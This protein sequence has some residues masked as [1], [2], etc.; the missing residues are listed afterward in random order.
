[1]M[2][3]SPLQSQPPVEPSPRPQGKTA[4]H[5]ARAG[6]EN[7]MEGKR[8]AGEVGGRRVLWSFAVAMLILVSVGAASWLGARRMARMNS[9][10]ERSYQ[11]LAEVDTL[12][13]LMLGA[14]TD[15]RGFMLTGQDEFL[16]S[17]QAAAG[18]WRGSFERLRAGVPLDAQ[19]EGASGRAARLSRIQKLIE[20]KLWMLQKGI[21]TRRDGGVVGAA[22]LL[23]NGRGKLVMDQIRGEVAGLK[24]DEAE[25]IRQASLEAG[26]SAR[27]LLWITGGGS[28]WALLLAGSALGRLGR[29][30]RGREAAQNELKA[31]FAAMNEIVLVLGRDGKYLRVAA[32]PPDLPLEPEM[33]LGRTLHEVWPGLKQEADKALALIA[34]V[35]DEDLP[36]EFEYWLPSEGKQ[37][38]FAASVVPLTPESVLWV[39]RDISAQ[40][41][42]AQRRDLSRAGLRSV[43]DAA[44]ELLRTPDVDA[45]LRRAVEL[46]REKFGLERAAIFLV[47]P[48]EKSVR[49]TYGTDIEGS[50]TDERV[51]KLPIPPGQTWRE[52]YAPVP[53][54]QRWCVL[55]ERLLSTWDGQ[56]NQ[57]TS[58]RSEAAV[59]LI[60][61]ATGLIGSFHNDNG[62]S[63]SSIDH[64]KQELIAV[65][66]SILGSLI[67]SK[68]GEDALRE[69]RDELEG[70]VRSRTAELVPANDDLQAQIAERKRAQAQEKALS[71]GL[72]SILS[73][74][75]DLLHIENL[76]ALLRR[77]IELGR[78]R[79]G[80]ERCALFLLTPDGKYLQGAYGINMDGSIV[81]QNRNLVPL[82]AE[83]FSNVVAQAGTRWF[84]MEAHAPHFDW[85]EEKGAIVETGTRGWQVL[86]PIRASDGAIGVLFNDAAISGAALDEVTQNTVTLF[87]SLLGGIIER[88]KAEAALRE[89][90]ALLRRLFES[91]PQMIWTARTDG[92]LEYFNAQWYLYSGQSREQSDG[93]GWQPILHPEDLEP[94]LQQWKRSLSTGQEL[95]IE[96][97]LKR[98][99][100]L[101]RWHLCRAL[102]VRSQSG[103]ITSWIG[104]S[105]DIDDQKKA[106]ET[107]R[108]SE[109]RFRLLTDSLP[110]VVWTASPQGIIT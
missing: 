5:A 31:L 4:H 54:G 94:S 14:E 10:I 85:D 29:D 81:A 35:L 99:D 8:S 105:T 15:E 33:F 41:R 22:R 87:A 61:S 63:Q 17:Y 52:V 28:L 32:T 25:R 83:W 39:A 12:L 13:Q 43:L 24:Q 67:Q 56:E 82:G 48:A 16:R 97:R 1:M 100:G 21:D 101:Y 106:Q 40:K 42:A 86:T 77:S 84:L 91:M 68:R 37:V 66:C 34:R 27:S 102:P 70:R 74:A 79:L 50:T 98:H 38:W 110:Q 57:L 18:L 96:F 108:A 71:Q 30:I 58:R 49:A 72:R 78:E 76:D 20:R 107:L 80:L 109:S 51:L 47:S 9:E 69:G 6:R 93:W 7:T 46:G 60:Q 88:K 65:Y 53:D 36:Q 26:E 75:D 19:D 3:D 2:Q 64:E 90:E 92:S 73:C 44:D 104:S 59:T 95:N 23:S 55:P 45:L 103:E 62:L 11:R 89:S